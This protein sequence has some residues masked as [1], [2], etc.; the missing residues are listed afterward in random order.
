MS[1]P[2]HQFRLSTLLWITAFVAVAAYL[3]T[4]MRHFEDGR[5]V[6]VVF[7]FVTIYI[8]FGKIGD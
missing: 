4:A 6:T 5:A 1:R 2:R 8:W 3:T 7:I